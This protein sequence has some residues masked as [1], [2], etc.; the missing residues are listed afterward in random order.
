MIWPLLSGVLVLSRAVSLGH[1][2]L[3]QLSVFFFLV[4]VGDLLF[5][6]HYSVE[7]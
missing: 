3:F 7:L 2:W 5:L 4:S 6:V 1:T